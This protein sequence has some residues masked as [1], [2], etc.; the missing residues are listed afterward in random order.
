MEVFLWECLVSLLPSVVFV[1]LSVALHWPTVRYWLGLLVRDAGWSLWIIMCLLLKLPLHRRSETLTKQVSSAGTDIWPHVSESPTLICKSTALAS[2][3]LQHCGSLTLPKLSPGWPTGDPHLQTLSSLLWGHKEDSVQFSRDHLLLSDGGIVALDWAVG[4]Q[5]SE[6]FG[7]KRWDGRK[8]HHSGGKTLGCFSSTPPVLLLI[9]Q[10]WGGM[11]LH[12]KALS[13]VALQ[14]GFY[15]VVFH[16]RGTAGCPLTTA[17]LTEFGDPADLEQA[18]AYIHSRHPSSVL[19]AVSEGSGSGILLSYLG[20]CGSSSH[21][22]AAAAISPVLLGQLWFEMDMPPLYHWGAL[23]FRKQ[24][25]RRYAS[26]FSEFLDVDRALNCSSLRDFEEILFC[27]SVQSQRSTAGPTTNLFTS[28]GVDP[29]L[30]SAP[31]SPQGLKPSVTR[32][33]VERAYSANNWSDYWERNEP[34]RE[35][36]E[37]A[38]PV[39]CICSHDDPILPPASTLPLNLFQNNPY[40]LLLMTDRGGHCGFTMEDQKEREGMEHEPSNWSHVTVLEYFKVVAD[41]LKA[42]DAARWGSS[43]G[44]YSQVMQRTRSSPTDALRRRRATVMKRPRL[45]RLKQICTES[46]NEHFTWKRSYTR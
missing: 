23:F 21:L 2:Y 12:L 13:R 16:P 36:D 35:A 1:L 29:G 17:R 19:L 26:S 45:Q 20:E 27:S 25:L 5:T 6:A 7:R 4:T 42:E 38:V 33:L 18:V 34:L 22:T 30:S 32:V 40:F 39:L 41:F 11:T 24:Q 46:E 10:V 15:V 28:A 8:E 43:M 3:L 14:Q 31:P 44:E 37:V 9:P